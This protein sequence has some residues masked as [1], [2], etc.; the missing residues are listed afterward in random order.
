MRAYFRIILM[1]LLLISGITTSAQGLSDPALQAA[2]EAANAAQPNLGRPTRWEFEILLPTNDSALSCPLVAG[3]Q[4]SESKTPII[5]TLYYD[6]PYIVHVASD[7]SKAQPCDGKFPNMGVIPMPA[8]TAADACTLTP[9]GPFANVRSIPDAE[10]PQLGTIEGSRP[11]LGRNADWTWYLVAEGWVAG[12]VVTTMGNCLSNDLSIRSNQIA[13]YL[14]P[15]VDGEVASNPQSANVCPPD[16]AGYMPP[17]ISTGAA[18]ARI[19]QGGIPNSIRSLP[20]T[21]SDRLGSIQPGRQLDFVHDGPLCGEG[22]V[23]WNV[24]VDGVRGWTVESNIADQSY[25]IE[26][27]GALAI[28][29]APPTA[30]APMVTGANAFSMTTTTL[31]QS[32]ILPDGTGFEA[33]WSPS[34]NR[35]AYA[36]RTESVGRVFVIAYPPPNTPPTESLTTDITVSSLTYSPDGEYVAIGQTDK[37]LTLTNRMNRVDVPMAHDGAITGL[38]FSPDG[39]T[40]ATASGME[41]EGADVWAVRLWDVAALLRGDGAA[42]M[43]R[44]IRFPYPPIDLT[45]TTDGAY[46]AIVGEKQ[47]EPAGAGLWIYGDGGRGENVATLGLGVTLEPNFVSAGSGAQMIF[48]RENSLIVYDPTTQSERPVFVGE[49]EQLFTDA[50]P[51]PDGQWLTVTTWEPSASGGAVQVFPLATLDRVVARVDGSADSAAFNADNTAL[52]VNTGTGGLI[53]YTP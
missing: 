21:T 4:T 50:T 8:P 19:E 44:S 16:Y 52:M 49:P 9:S 23:W 7:G 22:Y 24:T 53:F 13:S 20:T 39:A 38:A 30:V 11:A 37:T 45:F 43:L 3:V 41:G 34:T 35:V 51:S 12:T 28:T 36:N 26:P 5:V 27:Q 17:R 47:N 46:L 33:V 42:A 29:P 10:A 48:A 31:N 14:A 18:T 15:T 32:A 25:Y 40:L 2:I 6:M 1:T